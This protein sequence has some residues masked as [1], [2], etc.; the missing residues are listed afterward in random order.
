MGR[1]YNLSRWSAY[2]FR[3]FSIRFFGNF[4]PLPWAIDNHQFFNAKHLRDLNAG[5]LIEED[6]NMEKSVVKVLNDIKGENKEKLAMMRENSFRAA[7]KHP[8]EII[9]EEIMRP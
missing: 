8:E 6:E 7:I 4:I 5:F 1:Y 2:S 3:D 9:H